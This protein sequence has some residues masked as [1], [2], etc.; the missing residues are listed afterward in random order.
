M[1]VTTI[2]IPHIRHRVEPLQ[3]FVQNNNNTPTNIKYKAWVVGMVLYGKIYSKM[4]A[5]Y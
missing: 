4:W 1:N 5:A 3:L 2:E